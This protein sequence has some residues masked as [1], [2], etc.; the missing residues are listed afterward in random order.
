MVAGLEGIKP[1]EE[2]FAA[3]IVRPERG[4]KILYCKAEGFRLGEGSVG[5]RGRSFD[6]LAR[7][8]C[9]Q[10]NPSIAGSEITKDIGR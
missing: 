9:I 10:P 8:D 5:D 6:E 7:F 4:D 1:C 3:G 2:L